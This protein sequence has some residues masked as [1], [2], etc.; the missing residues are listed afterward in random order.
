[1]SALGY[2]LFAAVERR[3]GISKADGKFFL[4]TQVTASCTWFVR[5]SF[6]V[7]FPGDRVF[8]TLVFQCVDVGA[9]S[10]VV[11]MLGVAEVRL[12]FIE[13]FFYFF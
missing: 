8:L 4:E 11:P 3:S 9:E 7:D 1:M 5:E 10:S 12:M 13:A 2:H 6:A